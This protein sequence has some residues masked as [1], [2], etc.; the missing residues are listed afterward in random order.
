MCG[1]NAYAV[2]RVCPTRLP[3]DVRATELEHAAYNGDEKRQ[4]FASRSHPARC[5][6]DVWYCDTQW[7]PIVL[8]VYYTVYGPQTGC[9]TGR[10]VLRIRYAMSG[11]DIV[12][13]ATRREFC[14]GDPLRTPYAMSC[15]H[16]AY[17]AAA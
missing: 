3:C 16:I 1:E 2:S 6:R 4:R 7:Q 13:R 14:E 10:M 9:C 8:R 11:T 12:Y 17:A 15:T 5:R